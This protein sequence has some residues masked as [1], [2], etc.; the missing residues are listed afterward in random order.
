MERTIFSSLGNF[1]SQILARTPR[2]QYFYLLSRKDCARQLSQI[3]ITA[4]T[5]V[6]LIRWASWTFWIIVDLRPNT[7][8]TTCDFISK[9]DVDVLVRT[10][11]VMSVHPKLTDLVVGTSRKSGVC[12][13]MICLAACSMLLGSRFARYLEV[14][15]PFMTIG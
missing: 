5:A 14:A 13:S 8:E 12:T 6:V 2:N 15:M 11:D 10:S 9:P 3:I 7:T 4:L 1:Q